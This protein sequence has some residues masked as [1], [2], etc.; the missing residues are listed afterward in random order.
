MD[1]GLSTLP[2]A[3]PPRL[4][5]GAGFVNPSKEVAFNAPVHAR[6]YRAQSPHSIVRAALRDAATA[7][8]Y[9]DALDATGAALAA[10]AALVRAEVRHG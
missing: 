1:A 10:I 6:P 4:T 9:Q 3:R 5:A 2:C 7:S 8:T